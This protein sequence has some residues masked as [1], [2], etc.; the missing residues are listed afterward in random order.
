MI[1]VTDLANKV[2]EIEA[3]YTD[4]SD[5]TIHINMNSDKRITKYN[6]THNGNGKFF[7]T[8]HGSTSIKEVLL[9]F[10]MAMHSHYRFDKD[11][12]N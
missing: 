3:R 5:F 7:D 11:K 4:K 1:T 9:R 8:G 2:A 6:I 10:E 12:N